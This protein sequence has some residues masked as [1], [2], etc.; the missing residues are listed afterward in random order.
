MQ[1]PYESIFK[2]RWVMA[3]TLAF[4][5]AVGSPTSLFRHWTVVIVI[6]SLLS[7]DNPGFFV[8]NAEPTFVLHG[9]SAPPAGLVPDPNSPNASA[10]A[11]ITVKMLGNV[12]FDSNPLV[13]VLLKNFQNVEETKALLTIFSSN[14]SAFNN[15]VIEISNPPHLARRSL[16]ETIIYSFLA[17][18]VTNLCA[19]TG[20]FCIPIKR[21]RHFPTLLNFMMALAVG[22]LFCTAVLVLIPEWSIASDND[23]SLDGTEIGDTKNWDENS[24]APKSDFPQISGESAE[25]LRDDDLGS[26]DSVYMSQK[27]VIASRRRCNFHFSREKFSKIAPVAWMILFGDAFHNFMDGMT[28]GVG[29]TES[30]TIG[31]ALTLSIIFEE[32][33]TELGDFAILVSSGFS[34]KSA[35]CANFLSACTTYLG[36]IL[37]LLIGEVSTGALYVFAITA[38]FFLYISLADM[39]PNIREALEELE[40]KNRNSFY[41]FLVQLGGLI[42]GFGCVVGIT[43]VSDLIT[44]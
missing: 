8:A 2:Y 44:L 5:T 35:V 29:F 20:F 26:I 11:P 19:L 9:L 22:A 1:N 25:V 3:S 36:V 12:S 42:A 21:S 31:I 30:P 18:T 32:L 33:P 16:V 39:T 13:T 27:S 14:D 34:I 28:I 15:F 6:L 4:L 43:L 37:G 23:K 24:N 7:T 10:I 41:L 38:G 17:V 40:N